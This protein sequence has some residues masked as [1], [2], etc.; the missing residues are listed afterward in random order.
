MSPDTL[1]FLGTIATGALALGG[2]YLSVRQTG[3][4]A[5]TTDSQQII[6]QLQE[7]LTRVE[8]RCTDELGRAETRHREE[9]AR[10]EA[11]MADMASAMGRL[12]DREHVLEDYAQALRHHIDSNVGP[13]PP[14]WPAELL[15][16][17]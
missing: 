4:T 11:R 5:K 8:K 6:D 14:T 10:L 16:R 2:I 17:G 13:P 1:Q 15:R 12:E 3:R 7:E 9:I